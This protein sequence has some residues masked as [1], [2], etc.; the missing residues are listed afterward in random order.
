MRVAPTSERYLL[1]FSLFSIIFSPASLALVHTVI[2]FSCAQNRSFMVVVWLHY[3][4]DLSARARMI[5]CWMLQLSL[6]ALP[7]HIFFV[8]CFLFVPPFHEFGL[9]PFHSS[10]RRCVAGQREARDERPSCDESRVTL[11]GPYASSWS[12]PF[13]LPLLSFSVESWDAMQHFCRCWLLLLVLFS[14][15][16]F[17]WFFNFL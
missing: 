14:P 11:Y 15:S 13:C 7:L 16:N 8:S 17:F 4:I 5:C 9:T 1:C 12:S 6:P 3:G 2:L 10:C